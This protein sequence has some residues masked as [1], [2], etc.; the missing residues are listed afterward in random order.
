MDQKQTRSEMVTW[1]AALVDL[2]RNDPGIQQCNTVHHYIPRCTMVLYH[3]VT[4]WYS[5]KQMQT[6][7]YRGTPMVYHGTTVFAVVPWF[8]VVYH[9]TPR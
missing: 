8:T 6:R 9:G 2:A 3:G 4:P 1:G 5:T 7:W